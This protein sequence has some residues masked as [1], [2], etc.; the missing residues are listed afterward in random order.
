MNAIKRRRVALAA[1]VLAATL[2]MTVGCYQRKIPITV[3][4]GRDTTVVILK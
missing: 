3:Q 1:L 2:V 4:P